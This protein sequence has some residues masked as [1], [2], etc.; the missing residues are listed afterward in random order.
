MQIPSEVAAVKRLFDFDFSGSWL[1]RFLGNIAENTDCELLIVIV[2]K[3]DSKLYD[4][5]TY[6]APIRH[7]RRKITLDAEILLLG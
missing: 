2:K 7:T 4:R 6:F 3:R 5:T 1:S